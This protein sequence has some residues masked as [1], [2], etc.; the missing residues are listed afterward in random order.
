ML[1]SPLFAWILPELAQSSRLRQQWVPGGAAVGIVFR[2]HVL[3]W[4]SFT[5]QAGPNN[6]E[7]PY[8]ELPQYKIVTP[9]YLALDSQI[10]WIT[11]PTLIVA[12]K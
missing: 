1:L 2:F 9:S 11:L 8:I 12:V 7:S 3:Q 5:T 4:K 6:N 10:H